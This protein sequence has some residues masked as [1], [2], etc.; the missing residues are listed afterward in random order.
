[1][2]KIEFLLG[3]TVVGTENL[4]ADPVECPHISWAACP[5]R[6]SGQF[7][8]DTSTLSE[9]DRVGTLRVT[10]AAGNRK[11]IRHPDVINVSRTATVAPAAAS[12]S[13]DGSSKLTAQFAANSGSRHTT[14]FGRVARVRGRLV[15]ADGRPIANARLAVTEKYDSGTGSRTAE[16]MTGADGKYSYRPSGR[17][18]SR[19]IEVRYPGSVARSVATKLRLVVK[20]SST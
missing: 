12:V 6:Y 7:S 17:K 13:A 20:A 15:D 18:P 1:M 2:A 5:S 3:S 9:G 16:V 11:L 4:D 14:S 19:R 10:D 8:I